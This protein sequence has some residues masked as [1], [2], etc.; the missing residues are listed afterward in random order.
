VK[1]GLV[2]DIFFLLLTNGWIFNKEIANKLSK[3][4]LHYM[5][6]SIDGATASTHDAIRRRD[7]SWKRAVN[8][9]AMV[10]D[11]GLPLCIAST[12]MRSN[13]NELPEIIDLAAGIGAN[14]IIIDGFMS[15][16]AAAE[17]REILVLPNGWRKKFFETIA[18]KRKE[19]D[20][21]IQILSS[22]DPV[23]QLRLDIAGPTKVALIRP[24][25]DVKLDCVSP[26]VFG[27]VRKY[28]LEQIWDKSM[29]SGWQKTE[30]INFVKAITKDEDLV[31]NKI[32]PIPHL[33]DNID[34][35]HYMS[36][37]GGAQ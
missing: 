1:A 8:A 13:Y 9:A 16:G 17:N 31:K 3:Y 2:H 22:M 37:D 32:F 12:L 18:Q 19:Y 34:M 30:V 6:I 11:V 23:I 24:S 5:Q 20:G 33:G 4:K 28:S 27:N 15:T 10:K 29:K 7:G 36:N 14:Q 26:F 35:T 21:Q 25:G